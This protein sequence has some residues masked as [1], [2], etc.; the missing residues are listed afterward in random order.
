MRLRLNPAAVVIAVMLLFTVGCGQQQITV[1][2]AN[3]VIY[4]ANEAAILLGTLQHVAIQMNETT[5]CAGTEC[6]P[7]LSERDTR[8]VV[9]IITPTL[10]VMDAIPNGWPTVM[11][12]A[13][14]QIVSQMDSDGRSKLAPYLE[15]AKAA[16]PYAIRSR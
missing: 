13:I 14:D 15:A 12:A 5:Q 1:P 8:V 9:S 3:R 4:N 11:S 6:H 16:I 2:S 10:K 7:I